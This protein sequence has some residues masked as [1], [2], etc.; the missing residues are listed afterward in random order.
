LKAISTESLIKRLR[1]DMILKMKIQ[2]DVSTLNHKLLSEKI[3][4]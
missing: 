1:A 4:G 3:K 2:N